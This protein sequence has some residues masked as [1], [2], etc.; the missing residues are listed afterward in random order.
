[1]AL[2]ADSTVIQVSYH[3]ANFA[4][5][6]FNYFHYFSTRKKSIIICISCNL[7]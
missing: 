3:F 6:F 5:L 2:I 1:M 4:D 7:K